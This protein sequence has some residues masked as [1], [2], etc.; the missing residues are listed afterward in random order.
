MITFEKIEKVEPY[1]FPKDGDPTLDAA[2]EALSDALQNASKAEAEHDPPEIK[3]AL[4][5]LQTAHDETAK[6]NT[7]LVRYI[8]VEVPST[9]ES[10]LRGKRI[11][12]A[13]PKDEGTVRH[14]SS[15]SRKSS[16][17]YNRSTNY[18]DRPQSTKF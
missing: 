6:S 1:N 17:W 5:N 3:Q 7:A 4:G 11:F 12:L 9:P 14:N 2:C 15:I 16:I 13:L 8:D 10:P 18:V